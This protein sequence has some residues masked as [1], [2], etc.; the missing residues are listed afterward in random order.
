MFVVV[1]VSLIHKS[2]SQVFFDMHNISR[3]YHT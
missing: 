1:A 2:A 3:S